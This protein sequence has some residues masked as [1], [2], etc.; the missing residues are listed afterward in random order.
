MAFAD[1]CSGRVDTPQAEMLSAEAEETKLADS[2]IS[3]NARCASRKGM[4]PGEIRER[5]V[6]SLEDASGS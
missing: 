3:D 6:V 4:A 1:E 5:L 2:Q